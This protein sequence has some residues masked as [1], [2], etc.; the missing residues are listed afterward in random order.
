[1]A[2][3]LTLD[4]PSNLIWVKSYLEDTQAASVLLAEH[5]R[6]LNLKRTKR[7]EALLDALFAGYWELKMQAT[8]SLKKVVNQ[9]NLL[10]AHAG[11]TLVT[12]E[13]A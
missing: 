5:K 10:F 6:L 13:A 9:G 8:E 1:M 3:K 2:L 4:N 12:P 11:T 7:V